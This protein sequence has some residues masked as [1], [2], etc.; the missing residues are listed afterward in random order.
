MSW[1]RLRLLLRLWILRTQ[2]RRDI[3]RLDGHTIGDLG[4]TPSQMRFEAQ[5]PFWR[6]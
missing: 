4:L 2:S 3:A 6:G 5:K 1:H